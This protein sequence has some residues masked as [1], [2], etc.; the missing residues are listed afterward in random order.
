MVARAALVAGLLA[1]GWSAAVLASG[2]FDL[3]PV[4]VPI[5]ARTPWP[6]TIAAIALLLASFAFNRSAVAA[7]TEAI[8]VA[9]SRRAV[10]LALGLSLASGA[11]AVRFGT[12]AVGGSDSNC[13]VAQAERWAAGTMLEP[14]HPGSPPTGPTR[15]SRSPQPGSCRRD[16]SRVPSRLSAQQ[17]LRWPWRSRG[18]SAPRAARYSPSSP[19][20]QPSSCSARSS[21]GA[22]SSGHSAACTRP[23]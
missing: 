23:R 11:A 5:I 19:S 4:G 2:G 10:W 9:M 8:A 15:R 7:S 13:Y 16:G 18:R 14:V 21:W 22:G 12:E 17:D 1:L 3:R 20:A 6:T